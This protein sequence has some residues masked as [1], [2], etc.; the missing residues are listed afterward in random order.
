MMDDRK[1]KLRIA[2][3]CYFLGTAGFYI[4]AIIGFISDGGMAVIDLLLGSA[5]LCIGGATLH[6]INEEQDK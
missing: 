3:I 5:L 6:R 4:G 1:K 2:A